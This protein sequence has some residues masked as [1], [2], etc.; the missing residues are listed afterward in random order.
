MLVRNRFG[1]RRA[2]TVAQRVDWNG[3]R[4]VEVAL[5]ADVNPPVVLLSLYAVPTLGGA[6]ARNAGT[7]LFRNAV[8]TVAGSP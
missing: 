2:L 4:R 8:V 1:E 5:P 7:L 6:K 3:W